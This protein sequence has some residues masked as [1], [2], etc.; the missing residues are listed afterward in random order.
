MR[1]TTLALRKVK[2]EFSRSDQQIGGMNLSRIDQMH[3]SDLFG[4]CGGTVEILAETCSSDHS[5][6]ML[7]ATKGESRAV[8]TVCITKSL[9][10]DDKVAIQIE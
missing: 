9:Q 8:P 7:V 4:D 2:L 1:G 10:T 5:P 3:V 6:L